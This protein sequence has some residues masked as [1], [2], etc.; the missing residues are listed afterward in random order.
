MIAR[1]VLVDQAQARFA[2]LIGTWKYSQVL[3]GGKQQRNSSLEQS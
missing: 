2:P 3:L 1:L